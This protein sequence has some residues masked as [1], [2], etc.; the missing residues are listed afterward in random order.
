MPSSCCLCSGFDETREHL[1][2]TCTYSEQLW[3]LVQ[4]RLRLTPCIFYTWSSLHAW[5]NLKTDSAPPILRKL[6]AQAAI[7]HLWKQRNNILHNKIDVPPTVLFK[8]LDRVMCNTISARRNRKQ[9]RNLM[10]LWIR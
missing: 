8:E 1:L 9:F 7:Y 2:L 3:R 4:I 5:T 10:V 6:A